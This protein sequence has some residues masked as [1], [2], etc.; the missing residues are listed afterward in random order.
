VLNVGIVH[1]FVSKLNI[2]RPSNFFF[3]IFTPPNIYKFLFFKTAVCPNLPDVL[4]LSALII[5]HERSEPLNL[6]TLGFL[7]ELCP[8]N[9]I[10]SY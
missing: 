10:H 6:Q 5:S 4:L 3:S 8:P 9:K 2:S 7:P 1:F